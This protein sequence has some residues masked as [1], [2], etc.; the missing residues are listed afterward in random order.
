MIFYTRS[1]LIGEP[2]E[3]FFVVFE[4]SEVKFSGRNS[5]NEGFNHSIVFSR[6][7]LRENLYIFRE[8]ELNLF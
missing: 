1:S 8:I 2:V 6:E 3:F 4:S 7:F 5:G